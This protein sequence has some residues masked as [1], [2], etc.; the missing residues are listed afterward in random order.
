MLIGLWKQ[1]HVR[2]HSSA[3]LNAL[4]V[5]GILICS[6]S[7]LQYLKFTQCTA[8]DS[9][10]H[11]KPSEILLVIFSTR[12]TGT[13]GLNTKLIKDKIITDFSKC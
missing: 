6:R 4:S 11:Q 7:F 9:G 3:Y 12:T 10:R 5:S 1:F 2:T 8:L 13:S